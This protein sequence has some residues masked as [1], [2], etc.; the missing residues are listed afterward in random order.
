MSCIK[1]SRSDR[2]FDLCN[3]VVMILVV[4]L[5]AYPLYFVII[6]SVSDP[7]KVVAGEVYFL[8]KD[9]TLEAYRNVFKESRIW[10]GYRNS[11]IYTVLGTM[12][13]LILTVPC[14]YVLSRKELRGRTVL[15]IY[16]LIP[17]Y[18]GGGLVPTY[19]QV[20]AL[21]LVNQPYTLVLLGGL[22]IYNMIVTRV[23]FQTS[24]PDSLYGAAKIDGASEFRCFFRIMLP[25]AKPILAVMALYYAVWRWNDYFNALIYTSNRS[26]QPL[27]MVL[28]GILLLN[29]SMSEVMA[30]Q[31]VDGET[32]RDMA[33][34]A[35]VAQTMK[36]ALIFIASAPMLIMY[37]FVQKY[38]V[39]GVMIGSIKG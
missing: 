17:M 23:Y 19:L 20:R 34:L 5:M 28:R 8:P 21:N 38:F 3:M 1:K 26:Y 37:P 18:F 13:N 16:F 39:K 25:L 36:Y 11:I 30:E 35:Y 33:R 9:V 10:L 22:N 15:S 32:I 6:A 4:L 24:I 7:Y 31:T 29:E 12:W 2:I 14:A 27:Q